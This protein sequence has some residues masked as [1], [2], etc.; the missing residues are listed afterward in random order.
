MTDGHTDQPSGEASDAEV[1]DAFRAIGRYFVRFSQLIARMRFAMSRRLTV[2]TD[3]VMELGEMAFATATAEQVAD[4]FFM[5][6]RFLG[7]YEGDEQNI[8]NTLRDQVRKVITERNYFAHGDWWIG[9][10]NQDPAHPELIRMTPRRNK[11]D[12]ADLTPYAPDDLDAKSDAML[13][14]IG[15][16]AEFGYLAL[17]LAVPAR[18]EW[19]GTRLSA[20]REYRV[21]DVFTYLPGRG[22]RNTPAQVTRNGPR[23]GEVLRTAQEVP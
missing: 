23:I 13:A 14:L 9:R 18:A 2:D 6:C 16:V 5:M 15:D 20:P 1:D 10:L 17:G 19:G 3:D 22:S 4:S 11:G 21:S 8:A 12:F 7:S